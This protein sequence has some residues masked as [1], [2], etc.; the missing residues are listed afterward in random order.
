LD[1]KEIQKTI[2]SFIDSINRH[3]VEDL[4]ALISE[5]HL[6]ID[7]L[8]G[9]ARGRETLRQGWTRYF[10]MFPDY[11]IEQEEITQSGN[12][13]GIFGTARG[14]Y[15]PNGILKSENRWEIPAAW[16]GVVKE[17]LV[18]EWRIYCN[19]DTVLKIMERTKGRT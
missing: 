15:A 16:K 19:I 11:R 10:R 1:L 6:F 2:K 12:V 17:G 3:S 7:A 5:D 13:A 4:C 18:S 9:L 8:G 14:T